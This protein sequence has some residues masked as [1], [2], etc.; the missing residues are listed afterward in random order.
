M[1][2]PLVAI[3]GRPN[4][5]K[6][7]L[8]NRF[9]QRRQAVVDP[10]AGVTRDRNYA[11]CDW[12]GRKFRLVDT[13]GMVPDTRDKMEKAILDQSNF[14]IHEADLVVLVLD[15]MVGL[16]QIDQRLARLLHKSGCTCVL[17]AN[18][19]D[20]DDLANE[21]YALNRLG[22]GTPMP[23]S[24]TV[25]LGIGDLLDEIVEALP[26]EEEFVHDP[27]NIRVA[28]VGRPNV[29]KS[30]F[31]NRLLGK[32]R[33]IVSDIAGTTR[34]AV[35]SPFEHEGKAYTLVDT[36]GLRRKYKVQENIEFYTTLRAERAIDSC[37]V[38]IVLVDA[39]DSFTSQDQRV[40]AQVMDTR[41][42]AV[43][44]V[45]KWDL[46][47]KDTHTADKFSITIREGMARY[48]FV[49][50]IYVSAL[51]G[52]RLPKVLE[53]VQKVNA[54]HHKKI[55]T[56]KL[57]DFLQRVFGRR[58]PPAKQGKYIQFNY[59]VQ[60]EVAPPTFVFFC[61]RPQLV[62]KSYMNYLANQ[63]RLEF[64]FE[65]VPIRLKCRKK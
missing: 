41:R 14:A 15:A 55:S 33:L 58:K 24:A 59:V 40:L 32:E 36:A 5:G 4:V 65:G 17:V 26:T 1:S 6:S 18:K 22:L 20:N 48:S 27:D 42:P 37:D 53:L 34:D 19:A 64:G 43:L 52:Q 61:N 13:G 16:D 10:E 7:S 12:N 45:N 8:F 49:P 31:I 11:T 9:L 38:A 29:G 35:D 21:A 63:L 60:T 3:V 2:L 54:E 30:S 56:A 62:D 47:E 57:N 39:A 51:T 46:I 25:G 28:L 44:A 50:L 23:V